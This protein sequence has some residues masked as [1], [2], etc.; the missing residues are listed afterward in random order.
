M[1]KNVLVSAVFAGVAA[2]LIA[3]ALQFMFVIPALLEGELFEQGIRVHFGAD[4]SPQSDRG[5]PGLGGEWGRHAMT[6]GFN[7]V[8][9]VGFGFLMVAA[10]ALAE[11]RQLT[12]ITPKQ[13]LIWGL[14]GF[15]AIQLAP[16]IGLPPVLPGTIGA[17]VGARQA[18]WLG[19]IVASALGLWVLA[20]GRGGIALAG[21]VLLAVPHLIGAPR[22][23][24]F[25]GVAPPELAAQFVT[26]SLGSA[27]V[28]WTCL[29]FV[30]AWCWT[31]DG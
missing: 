4:G 31:R 2:G 11:L 3:A 20:F 24:T 12:T 16:A 25:W 18:W 29:G 10:M 22:L 15:V 27:A 23:D 5:A 28:G 21:V 9:Y 7:V 19:T 6:I 1:N 26:V 13:G 30:A 14:A 17:E 8:T